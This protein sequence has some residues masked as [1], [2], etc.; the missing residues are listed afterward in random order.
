MEKTFI[1][2][3]KFDG[4]TLK[5]NYYEQNDVDTWNDEELNQADEDLYVELDSCCDIADLEEILDTYDTSYWIETE[6]VD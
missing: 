5:D 1:V 2:K 6:L 4:Q 3:V